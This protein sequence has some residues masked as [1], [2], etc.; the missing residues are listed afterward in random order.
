MFNWSTS[1]T[2]PDMKCTTAP[3]SH[4]R[5][6]IQ[7]LRLYQLY[8]IIFLPLLI[9]LL[10]AALPLFKNSAAQIHVCYLISCFKCKS[11]VICPWLGIL[12]IYSQCFINT[13]TLHWSTFSTWEVYYIMHLNPYTY[14]LL[15]RLFS[16]LGSTYFIDSYINLHWLSSYY[17]MGY[18]LELFTYKVSFQISSY[19]LHL[20]EI[21]WHNNKM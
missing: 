8:H 1:I 2:Q 17:Q 4:R 15:H 18:T 21:Q 10:S 9:R 19:M 6:L 13:S 7:G 5:K 12:C 3:T 16:K 20:P 14:S 11:T